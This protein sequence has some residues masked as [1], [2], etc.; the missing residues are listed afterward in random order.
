M[1]MAKNSSWE[2][3]HEWYHGQVGSE[4][5]YY[6]QQI[7]LPNVLRLLGKPRKVLDIGCGQGILARKLPKS[8]AYLGID[9]SSSLIENAKQLQPAKKDHFA[10]LDACQPFSLKEKAFSHSTLILS[11]QNMPHPRIVLQNAHDHLEEKGVLL[12]VLNHPCFRI[13]RQSGWIVDTSKKLQSRRTDCYMSPLEI[14]IQTHPSKGDQSSASLSFHYPLSFYA[15]TLGDAGFVIETIEE[16][17][18]D[19]ASTGANARMENRARKEF[20]LFLTLLAR[21]KP[22]LLS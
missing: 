19:K 18:S 21:K 2:S 13:P 22:T 17:C 7:I 11:L 6:H 1:K 12:I 20:P 14:P 10:I 4:G 3:M 15:Q 9:L 5:H 8:T 16:W